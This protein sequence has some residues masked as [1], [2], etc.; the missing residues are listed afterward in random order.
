MT[1]VITYYFQ[2]MSDILN[3]IVQSWLLSVFFLISILGVV[4]QLV[5]QS[6]SE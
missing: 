3:V 2:L 6:K 1:D 5:N 4:V